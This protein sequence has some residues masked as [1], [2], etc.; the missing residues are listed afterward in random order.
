MPPMAVMTGLSGNEMYCLHL[1]G[2][3]PGDLVHRQQRLLDGLHRQPRRRRQQLPRRRGRRRSPPSSTRAG[4][5]A[6]KRM[7]AEAGQRGGVGITGV[8]NELRHFHGNT[9]FLSV[10][11]CVHR[12]GRPAGERS[13]FT[14]SADGQEL[15]CQLDAGFTPDPVRLRQ[16]RLLDR[17]GRRDHRHAQEHG[18]RR[19][20]GVQRRLQPAPATSACSASS[21]RPRPCGANAV[22]GIETRT[23]PLPGRP[24]DADARHRLAPPRPAADAHA[25]SRSPAT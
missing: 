2:I 4:I 19:D 7:V 24:R 21:T 9:E 10:A 17:R 22:V 11:S 12:D 23:M 15:Y 20:Q 8:T 3:A 25:S 18:A 14:T 5:E 16:R 6:F 13:S 1:K